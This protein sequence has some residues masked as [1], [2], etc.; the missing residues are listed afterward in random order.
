M[1][2]TSGRRTDRGLDRLVAFSDGVVA[3]AI[4]LLVLP[5]LDLADGDRP[6]VE[7]LADSWPRF[8]AFLVTFAVVASYW[9]VHHRLFEMVDG[10][11][12]LLIWAN[13]L[14]LATIAFLP[15]AAQVLGTNDTDDMGVRALYIGALLACTT[16]LA[17]LDVVVLRSP[18]LWPDGVRPDIDP[19]GIGVR[20][21]AMSAAFLVGTFV[22]AVG[23]WALLLLFLVAPVARR[24]GR[25]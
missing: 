18:D 16:A 12:S 3:I 17:L 20:L 1:P 11:S 4:T 13:M 6:T 19:I 9:I 2:S 8:L 14:W 23:M 7:V 25:S 15:F 21:G 22:Q 24:V 5:L 10:Y